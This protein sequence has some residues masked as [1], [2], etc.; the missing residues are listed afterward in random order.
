MIKNYKPVILSTVVFSMFL[1]ISFG[2]A[3]AEIT[4]DKS[5][6]LKGEPIIISVTNPDQS[7][8]I[9]EIKII[10]VNNNTVVDEFIPVEDTFSKSYDSSTWESGKYDTIM[11]YEN[12][13]D[14]AEFEIIE[15]V[16]NS[17]VVPDSPANLQSSIVSPNQ[18]NL[19]WSAPINTG[20][21]AI[22]G[23]KIEVRVNTDVD[24]SVL[25]DAD[26]TTYSHIDLVPD[27]VYAYRVY[28]I[29][30]AGESEPSTITVQTHDLNS[31]NDMELSDIPTGV[32]AK[33]TSS[34]S[35]ELT[36]NP[37]TQTYGQTIQG[38]TIKQEIAPNVYSEV[39]SVSSP[40]FNISDLNPDQTYSFVIVANYV[41]SSSNV[42]EKATV[43]LPDTIN[44]VDEQNATDMQNPIGLKATTISQSRINLSWSAPINSTGIT[45]YKIEAKTS[46]ETDY[47]VLVENTGSAF[48]TN[49]SHTGLTAGL[50][51]Q[52]RVSSVSVDGTNIPSIVEATIQNNNTSVPTQL[53]PVQ[54]TI[55]TDK[56]VYNL[57]D[58]ITIS[59]EMSGPITQNMPIGIRIVSPDNTIVYVKNVFVGIDNTFEVSIPSVQRQATMW[60]RTG[61]YT[62]E[63]TYNGGLVKAI[64]IFENSADIVSEQVQTPVIT[65][66]EL[67]NL[68]N[69]N[70]VLQSTNQQLQNENAQ[71]KIQVE[72]LDKKI[73][74]LNAIIQEQIRVMLDA[75]GINSSN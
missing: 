33:A 73:K 58:S 51:Y 32:V 45:G 7:I 54:I 70:I 13:E 25:V 52:Y 40:I 72:E 17:L 38:Y 8:N 28:A 5:V 22:I 35:I 61:Q 19:S 26:A 12:I 30:A 46:T 47:T 50:T 59:G 44:D 27:T 67:D 6:Y 34:T 16:Q 18:V 31:L 3:F 69:Q 9:V 57:D 60:Q 62:I 14:Y 63:A 74:D 36:W 1:G 29:N 64:S 53:Q 11:Y 48:L 23:Y 66:N 41:L 2:G 71:F 49:Y 10:D 65:D 24:Y 75:L 15:N 56:P 21:S 20:D 37:P 55:S 68:K 39:A 43:T 42:S 4:T